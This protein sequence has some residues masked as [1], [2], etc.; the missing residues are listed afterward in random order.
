MMRVFSSLAVL[1]AG[2]VVQHASAQAE[3]GYELIQ[4]HFF[5]LANH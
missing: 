2:T 5:V 1:I 4:S 3:Y